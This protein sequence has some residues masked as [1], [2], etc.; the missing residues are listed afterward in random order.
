M[1]VTFYTTRV[2]LQ[3]LGVVDFGIFNVV[4]GVV[5]MLSFI[6]ASL[7]NGFQRFM[8][9]ELGTGNIEGM[10]KVFVSSLAV[11]VFL[12]FVI[13]LL[14]ETIGVWFL[15]NQMN[16]PIERADASF[17][18]FQFTLLTF[19]FTM[20]QIPFTSMVIAFEDMKFYA[21]LSIFDAFSRLFI[22][23]I[24]SYAS[25]D[26]MIF[27]SILISL[28][29][30][31][32][33]LVYMVYCA[34]KYA[35]LSMKFHVDKNIVLKISV[36]SGWNTFGSTAHLLEGQGINI[37]LNI[38]FGPVVNAARGIAFQVLSGLNSFITNL[39]IAARPQIIQSYSVQNITRMWFLTFQ[40]SKFSFFLMLLLSLPF[41]IEI[42]NVLSL[43]LGKGITEH[44]VSFTRIVILTGLLNVFATP[45]TTIVHATGKMQ[46]FQVINS[47]VIMSV[48]PISYC[49]LENGCFPE[50]VMILG[51]VIT[52][53]VQVVRLLLLKS[54]ISFS[55]K[56]YTRYVVLPALKVFC[57]SASLSFFIYW[58]V[59]DDTVIIRCLLMIAYAV[60]IVVGIYSVG[61]N[62]N[63][64]SI[65]KENI[66]NRL[67]K[68]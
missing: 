26:K 47:L 6:N 8:N 46:K 30:L 36:F 38:Y 42:K 1:I 17:Y 57:V 12:I 39:H 65:L 5:S 61:L 45:I 20:L 34:V 16:I 31:L 19:I 4:G 2:I 18:V 35:C 44:T 23:Y 62:N 52:V 22:V 56:D 41:F 14:G 64:K 29:S 11:Q 60:V 66:M 53:L 59:D 13:V 58:L 49:L 10:E 50:T 28:V 3:T 48:I 15:K 21:Y 63:E 51:L 32:T 9:I 43:W 33:L 55:M 25:Y 24:L 40:I 68:F 27:Y 7:A 54:I 67:L 37:L